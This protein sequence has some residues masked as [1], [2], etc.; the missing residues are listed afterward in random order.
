MIFYHDL[1]QWE[2]HPQAGIL[3]FTISMRLKPLSVIIG[4]ESVTENDDQI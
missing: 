3:G 2:G 4:T 1:K